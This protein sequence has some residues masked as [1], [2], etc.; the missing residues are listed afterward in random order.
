MLMK[1]ESR[2]KRYDALIHTQIAEWL[3]LMSAEQQSRLIEPLARYISETS[4]LSASEIIAILTPVSPQSQS[5]IMT[6]ADQVR[7]E[8]RREMRKEMRQEA[9]QIRRETTETLVKKMFSGGM[10]VEQMASF[11]DLPSSEVLQIIR[12]GLTNS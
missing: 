1:Y 12:A 5:E 2:R 8:A 10:P 6:A 3:S 7:A 11:V 9:E 4:G